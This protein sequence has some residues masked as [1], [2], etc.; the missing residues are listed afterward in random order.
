MTAYPKIMQVVDKFLGRKNGAK[1]SEAFSTLFMDMFFE[2][3]DLLYE[4][5]PRD[6]YE[7]LDDMNY[8]CDLYEKCP[9]IW[10][11][12]TFCLDEA[13]LRSKVESLRDALR[14]WEA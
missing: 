4:E 5:L 10:G 1:E 12:E 6:Q 3:S 7:L 8:T 14:R 11:A 2:L 13:Q 9:A